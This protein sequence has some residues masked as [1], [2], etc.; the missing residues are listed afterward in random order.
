MSAPISYGIEAI[1]SGLSVSAQEII[2]RWNADP[3]TRSAASQLLNKHARGVMREARTIA[4]GQFH[5]ERSQ[6]RRPPA[7]A[8]HGAHYVDSFEQTPNTQES[9]GRFETTVINTHPAANLIEWG[10]G[11]HSMPR[12]AGGFAEG[13]NPA[14]EDIYIFPVDFP[15]SP[16]GINSPGDWP[17]NFGEGDVF[18]GPGPINHPGHIGFRIFGRARARWHAQ[19]R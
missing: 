13:G 19:N 18:L 4:A 16:A 14:A 10:A 2:A 17:A 11:A 9:I 12:K 8:A 7:S 1:D 15:H 5:T 6:D 3:R